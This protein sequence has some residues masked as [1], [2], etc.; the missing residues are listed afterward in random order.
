MRNTLFHSPQN[1]HHAAHRLSAP[2][3]WTVLFVILIAL[4]LWFVPAIHW[5]WPNL[6]YP[7]PLP[8]GR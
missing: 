3:V 7:V 1:W 5:Y 2:V 6:F 4:C 8:L